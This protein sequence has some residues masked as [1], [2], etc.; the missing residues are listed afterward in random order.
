MSCQLCGKCPIDIL[1]K[2]KNSKTNIELIVGSSC[3]Q[4]YRE[5]K[6][7]NGENKEEISKHNYLDNNLYLLEELDP[8]YI[9]DFERF[10]NIKNEVVI[11]RDDLTRAFNNIQKKMDKYM[12]M[13]E[14]K[15]IS[16]LTQNELIDLRHSEI[17]SFFE[18]ME[19]YKNYS[20]T[21]LFGLNPKV[22][23]WILNHCDT[24]LL[25]EIK[26]EGKITANT[27]SLIKE[28]DFLNRA[29]IK[30]ETILKNS[31][32]QLIARNGIRFTLIFNENPNIKLEV[33]SSKFIARYKNF[34]FDGQKVEVD[35]KFI[36]SNAKISESNSMKLVAERIN[37][38]FLKESFTLYFEDYELDELAFKNNKNSLIYVVSYVNFI[39]QYKD[40]AFYEKNK[41]E[42]VNILQQIFS[43][44]NK[45]T[46]KDYDEHLKDLK[47]N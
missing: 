21:S 8:G 44:K 5:I 6:G 37:K 7:E 13:M 23:K 9:K 16:S 14:K 46:V 29:I 20:N 33:I 42:I 40:V 36:L 47:A 32:M 30:Y 35:P 38:K 4:N 41:N 28:P 45:Y 22:A 15:K 27:I 17:K 24:N 43:S 2:I 39:N 26:K 11:L 18:K 34:I 10:K 19:E 25:F 31:N 1:A 12:K 3:I